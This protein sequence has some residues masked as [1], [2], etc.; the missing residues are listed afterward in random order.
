[1]ARAAW[2]PA[3][4]DG[5]ANNIGAGCASARQVA[6][7]VGTSGAMRVVFSGQPPASLPAEVFC[8]RADHNRVVIGGALSDGGG[9]IRWLKEGL[10]LELLDD[11]IEAA[12]RELKPDSHGLTVLPFWSGERSTGWSTSATG[13]ITGLTSHTRPIEILLAAMEAICYRFFLLARALEPLAPEAEFVGAGNALLA[14]PTW[15]QML[16]DVLGQPLKLSREHQASCRG[17]ALL[18][19]ESIGTINTIETAPAEFGE[20]FTPNLARHQLYQQAI[21][22]QQNIYGRLVEN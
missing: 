7:M 15:A 22:R 17:A 16:S 19:L 11:Q 18:A 20:T 13:A 21:E 5:A 4:G 14:S 6:V 8:Y 10:A 1:L 12:L 2:F 9:L 3:I